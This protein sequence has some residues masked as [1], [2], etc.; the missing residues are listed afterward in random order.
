[1]SKYCCLYCKYYEA[2]QSGS[3]GTEPEGNCYN[4]HTEIYLVYGHECCEHYEA[5]KEEKTN[6][7]TR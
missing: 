6:E 4:L 5:R 2:K 7:S 1:M 3:E